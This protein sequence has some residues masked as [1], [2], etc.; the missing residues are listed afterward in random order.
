MRILD[1]LN[2]FE[3][4]NGLIKAH[5][6]NKELGLDETLNNFRKKYGDSLKHNEHFKLIERPIVDEIE[7]RIAHREQQ[8][9]LHA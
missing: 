1:Q 7:Q 2:L 4:Y 5:D 8:E 9:R 3:L 6:N